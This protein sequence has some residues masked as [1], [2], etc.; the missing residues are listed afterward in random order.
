[1]NPSAAEVR[2]LKLRAAE[3]RALELRA[4]EVRALEIRDE[5]VRA[6]KLRVPEVRALKLR[7]AEVRALKPRRAEIRALNLRCG[8][9]RALKLR[10]AE[11]R[12]LKLRAAEVRALKVRATDRLDPTGMPGLCRGVWRAAPSPPAHIVSKILQRGSHAL[13]AEQGCAGSAR[14]QGCWQHRCQ[15]APRRL[16]P[17]ICPDLI[18]GRDRL[19]ESTGAC[20]VAPREN[21]TASYPCLAGLD[22]RGHQARVS[23]R[24]ALAGRL[25]RHI[26]VLAL[27]L[28]EC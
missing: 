6:L 12:A 28:L 10:V 15:T 4:L 23:P 17:S 16:A 11:V 2:A 21:A 22:W 9:V 1:L 25:G 13:V 26:C 14:C 19:R 24:R 5:E 20:G 8:E 27:S 3:V 18:S 7:V